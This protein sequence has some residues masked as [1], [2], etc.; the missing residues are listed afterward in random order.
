MNLNREGIFHD[1]Y[2]VQASGFSD[3]NTETQNGS[4]KFRDI[5][6]ETIRHLMTT[7]CI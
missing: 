3:G 7:N 1:L 5:C 2:V 4:L 6:E